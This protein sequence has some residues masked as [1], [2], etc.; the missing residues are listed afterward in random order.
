MGSSRAWRAG[1]AAARG[2]RRAQRAQAGGSIDATAFTPIPLRLHYPAVLTPLEAAVISERAYMIT[3][4]RNQG[5]T[6]DAPTLRRLRCIARARKDR[7]TI[8]YLDGLDPS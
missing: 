5:A 6:L 7:G 1:S 8:A 2:L 4:V 3:L